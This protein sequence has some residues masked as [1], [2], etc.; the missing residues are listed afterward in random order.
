MLRRQSPEITR[1]RASIGGSLCCARPWMVYVLAVAAAVLAALARW[2]LVVAFGEMPLFITY[3]PA[4]ALVAM[5]LGARAAVLVTIL[6]A[7]EVNFFFLPAHDFLRLAT[8]NQAVA[9]GLFA[10]AGLLVSLM[11]ELLQRARQRQAGSERESLLRAVSE[12]IPDPLFLKDKNSRIVIANAATVQVIGKPADRIIGHTDAEFFD[13]PA[14]AQTIMANDRRVMESGQPEAVEEFISDAEG[15]RTFLSIKTPWCDAQGRIIGIIGCARDITDRKRA[16]QALR[17]EQERLRAIFDH[18]ALGIV[19]VDANERLIAANDRVCQI[20]GYPLEELLGKTVGE[21]TYAEDRPVSDDLN[22]RLQDGCL[23]SFDCEKRYLKRD[24]S[25]LWVHITVSAFRD[26]GGRFVRGIGTVEDIA[27]RKAMEGAL[28]ESEARFQALAA[29]TFEGIVISESGR[30]SDVNEQLA[31]MRGCEPAEMIG[32]EIAAMLPDEERERVLANIQAGQ[33]S[34]IEHD[35]LR[36]DG[37]RVAVEAHGKNITYQ[38]RSVRITAIHDIS[39]RKLAEEA[40]RRYE[41]LAGNSRDII[42]FTDRDTGRILE[43][44]TAAELAYRYSREELLSLTLQDLRVD[45][46]IPDQLWAVV[47]AK[48]ALFETVHQRRD[49]S[50]FPVEVSSRGAT[51]GRRR[52]SISVVRDITERKRAQEA[53]QESERFIKSVAGASPYWFYIFDLDTMGI[54]YANRP[55]LRDLGYAEERHVAITSLQGFREFM[56][57]EEMPHLARLLDEWRALPDGQIRDD[58][59]LLR[60]SDGTVHFFAGRELVFARRPDGSVRQILGSLMDITARKRAEEAMRQSE[61][62]LRAVFEQA[63]VGTGVADPAT[64]RFLEVNSRYC[65][66]TGY[67]E[68]EL[69]GM[70]FMDVTHPEDRL[71]DREKYDRLAASQARDYLAEKRYVR[72]DGREIWVQV[73][74]GMVRDSH[75]RAVQSI[76]VVQDITER[77]RWQQALQ[78][79]EAGLAA[80]QRLAHIGSWEWNITDDTARWSEETFRI[81]GVTRGQLERHRETFVGMIHPDDRQRTDQALADALQGVREYDLD[82]RICRPDGVEKVVHSQAEVLRNCSGQPII[83]RGTVHDITERKRAEDQLKELNTTLEQRVAER[84]AEAEHR[85]A[86]LQRLAAQLTQVEQQER[87]QLATLLHDHLQQLLVGAKFRLTTLRHQPL[88][89]KHLQSLRQ[90]AELIDASLKTSRSLTAELSPPILHEGTLAQVM[91][92]LARSA[93]DKYGLTVVVSADQEAELRVPE[94]RTLIFQAVRELLLNVAK[95]AGV[96][97][98]TLSLRRTAPDK[99]Q[100]VVADEG[101]GFD[102]AQKAAEAARD[103]LGGGLG[104]FSIRERLELMGGSMDIDS[105]PGGGARITLTAT[106]LVPA[107]AQLAEAPYGQTLTSGQAA[108]QAAEGRPQE[109]ATIRILLADDHEVVRSGLAR[110]LQMEPD[111]EIAGQAADGQEA[112]EVAIQIRPDVILMDVSM[113]RMSGVEAT[114]RIVQQMPNT[115]I[116]GLSMHEHD[117]VAASMK[118]AGAAMYLTKTTPPEALVAA[119][120]ECATRTPVVP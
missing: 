38:N 31:H 112:V 33:E 101:V 24:G 62:R 22:A 75:G 84:T 109:Q 82:Y 43:A 117:D 29:G 107:G 71:T 48:G 30:I 4:V 105:Q 40:L 77:R 34:H 102:W 96:N 73:A 94:I 120:R 53:L 8:V 108:G 57:P 79:S 1:N 61:A 104:L 88:Q 67:K 26:A 110:L 10:A 44:N 5:L 58:E 85:A 19:E 23:D 66:I 95:H 49:G 6:S 3:Y 42:L 86:Q 99:V 14:A 78:E 15:G 98:A 41:L 90:A 68:S 65:E 36:K 106:C 2:A 115:K 118:A 18:V 69:L 50:T 80:A 45:K 12:G 28:R 25:P 93:K 83:M 97:R 119:I 17:H 52:T 70:T 113:P 76:G 100:V 56:P 60:H 74:V 9:L 16:E 54:S 27:A 46:E 111:I 20:L 87:R 59:Y 64:G 114:R 81:F 35:I 11:A 32:M 47:D 116:I 72:K 103:K 91:Q 63:A 13:D 51:I 92:W 55:I 7:L 89:E 37:S 21:L 39:E